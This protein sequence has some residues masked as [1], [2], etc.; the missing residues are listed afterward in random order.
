MKKEKFIN[1][2]DVFGVT[3]GADLE[4][5]CMAYHR[6]VKELDE[7]RVTSL[8]LSGQNKIKKD[9]QIL[10][11]GLKLFTSEQ[12]RIKYDLEYKRHFLPVRFKSAYIKDLEDNYFDEI[13][14]IEIE[15]FKAKSKLKEIDLILKKYKETNY[16]NLAVKS[17]EIPRMKARQNVYYFSKLYL[18]HPLWEEYENYK[19]D[20]H[21]DSI[22]R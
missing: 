11:E 18:E 4:T 5:V 21:D 12:E 1:Y 15:L 6:K 22:K 9:Y 2:Y 7:K 16:Y 10:K 20:N 19:K 8:T 3:Y 13:M 17:L 14:G